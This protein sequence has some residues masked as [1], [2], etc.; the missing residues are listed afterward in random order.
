INNYFVGGPLTPASKSTP[1]SRG[2]G[3]FNLYRSGIYFDNNHDGV[4]NGTLVPYDDRGYPGITTEAFKSSPF[5][6]PM[7]NPTLTAGEAYQWVIDSVGAIYPRRDQVDEQ[8]V[9]DLRTIG[10]TGTYMYRE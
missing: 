1:I 8:M 4:L 7:A 2:T 6:Y 3:T 10:T 5:P 9:N